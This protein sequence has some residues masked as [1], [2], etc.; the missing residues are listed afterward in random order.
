MNPFQ[1]YFGT[2]MLDSVTGEVVPSPLKRDVD[3]WI[4]AIFTIGC[5]FGSMLV[6]W[7]AGGF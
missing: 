7:A 2:G 1:L 4:V 3:G 6:S 5:I